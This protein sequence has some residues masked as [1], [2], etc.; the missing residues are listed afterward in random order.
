MAGNTAMLVLSLRHPNS[1]CFSAPQKSTS[2]KKWKATFSVGQGT[3]LIGFGE[4]YSLQAETVGEKDKKW[5]S[6]VFCKKTNLLLY[7][8]KNY[9]E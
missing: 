6:K 3:K 5:R 2:T 1:G 7:C 4:N 9:N 8:E